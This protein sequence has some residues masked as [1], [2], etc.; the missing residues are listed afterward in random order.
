MDNVPRK[1]ASVLVIHWRQFRNDPSG[2]NSL[3]HATELSRLET[4][5]RTFEA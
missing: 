1:P 3:A 5:A 2:Q 4:F